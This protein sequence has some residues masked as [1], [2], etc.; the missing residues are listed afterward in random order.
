MELNEFK[1]RVTVEADTTNLAR[2][3]AELDKF[4]SAQD[5]AASASGRITDS[6]EKA[7]RSTLSAE[8][9]L[10][11]YTRTNDPLSQA[12]AKVEV[13]E[14]LIARAR[15]QGI[16]V[17]EANVRAL[18]NARARYSALSGVMQN[19]ATASALTGQQLQ[20]L[21]YTLN[22]VI[23]SA[24][25]GTPAFMILAQQG[26][27]VTQ[28]FGGVADTFRTLGPLLAQQAL[29]FTGFAVGIAGALTLAGAA[30]IDFEE[31]QARLAVSLNGIGRAAGMTGESLARL[32]AAAGAG[33]GLSRAA[34]QDLAA[35]Y[36]GAGIDGNVI[37]G[38]VGVTRR[39]A[40]GTGLDVETAG[41]QLAQAFA[42]PARGADELNRRLGFLDGTTKA[43]IQTQL[44][45]GNVSSAQAALF[46]RLSQSVDSLV[47]RQNGVR[48]FFD[49]L[50]N[51]LSNAY[52]SIGENLGRGI[53]GLTDMDQLDSLRGQRSQMLRQRSDGR[54]VPT[55]RL[56][57]IE[58]EIAQIEGRIDSA[59]R[60]AGARR[61]LNDANRRALEGRS[62]IE[63]LMP[64]VA[65]RNLLNNQ[66]AALG[67]LSS[68]PNGVGTGFSAAET[69]S[70]L[71]RL[72]VLREMSD[73]IR[74]MADEFRL[75]VD[76][77][78]AVTLAQR[79]SV[80]ARRAELQE[81]QRS[82]DIM[83]AALAG[84]MA[85]NVE[86]AR[87]AQLMRDELRNA[88]ADAR[89]VGLSPFQRGLQQIRNQNEELRRRNVDGGTGAERTPEQLARDHLR[90]AME[91]QR[92]TPNRP[93]V[94]TYTDS[95]FG[96]LVDPTVRLSQPAPA[97]DFQSIETDARR[98][99]A[100]REGSFMREAQLMPLQQAKG[101][102]EADNAM[103]RV[104]QE[105]SGLAADKVA[106]LVKQQELLN[107]YML[108]GIPVTQEMALSIAELGQQAAIAALEQ[109]R[110][111]RFVQTM[112]NIRSVSGNALGGFLSDL[113]RGKSGAEALRSALSNVGQQLI[114]IGTS[115]FIES[116]FGRSGTAGRG[117]IF[118][119]LL[120]SAL[121]I[122][123][124]GGSF[125]A[126]D[127]ASRAVNAAP[128]M[129]GPGFADGGIMTRF[130][131]APLRQYSDGGIAHSPQIALFGEG[132]GPEAFVPLKNGAIPVAIRQAN[133]S[134]QGGGA[135]IVNAGINVQG[136]VSD[137]MWP[138]VQEAMAQQ[139][140][141][142]SVLISKSNK[143][144]RRN[145]NNVA[146]TNSKLYG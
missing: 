117:S 3:T 114:Q 15:E 8:R 17:S 100:I 72:N 54:A 89:L 25:S 77:I 61:E 105:S 32:G 11:R 59:N 83:R 27:Q 92:S 90:R 81:L 70:A 111:Q 119:N 134:G 93:D 108:Q 146:S 128:G 39:F 45:Q 75:S 104:L 10:E 99:G 115:S 133:G 65:R 14:R 2:A 31:R 52:T 129:Y 123:G 64:E 122:G 33:S 56:Q 121:G 138:R 37:G 47:T 48:N 102:L 51:G 107:Q 130:G 109:E 106:A 19:T 143:D 29:S 112:D 7:A 126:S 131:P 50:R 113:A 84:E 63:D 116:L 16:P 49:I 41:Q 86:I 68:L 34:G 140:Q 18:D 97:Q 136:N 30:F 85:R 4:S 28:A 1:T 103:M 141:E 57:R 98:A 110:F 67:N 21:T 91:D 139:R 66:A 69:A 40:K 135:L 132:S 38:L 35:Q 62:I 73:P 20:T 118:G 124:G 6:Q 127:F 44:Q 36:A 94:L 46:E 60:A 142:I 43:L 120:S 76:A 71:S 88:Q 53:D 87:S 80:E 78:N 101:Q 26:G 42:D 96:S 137:D 79:T 9:A 12:L 23:A 5:R 13:G 58:D 144:L 82:G 125:T 22:D 24:A 55:G 145:I 95:V 74:Q